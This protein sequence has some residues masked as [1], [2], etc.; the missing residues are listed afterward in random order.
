MMTSL[1][2]AYYQVLLAQGLC[3]GLGSGCLFTPGA[4]V[5]STYFTTKKLVA[6]GIAAMGSSL[7]AIIYPVMFYYLRPQIGYPWAVRTIGFVQLAT[8]SVVLATMRVRMVTAR[9][10]KLFDWSIF[11]DAPFMLVRGWLLI[12]WR[13][14]DLQLI[15][16][17]QYSVGLFTGY[18]AIFIPFFYISNLAIAVAGASPT[19][20]LAIFLTMNGASLFG[21]FI[22]GLLADR[23]GPLNVTVPFAAIIVVLVWC[24]IPATSV[25]A[26]FAFA[27]MYGF[28]SG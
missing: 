10:K 23:Y 11:S 20:A 7:A 17:L 4:A 12:D 27:A 22:P 24:W 14:V 15:C 2:T 28:F 9:G 18:I 19:V 16:R 13:H 1:C 3:V 26:L 25:G 21:R 6:V 8:L 5:M